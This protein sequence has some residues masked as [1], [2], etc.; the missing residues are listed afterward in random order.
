MRNGYT[1]GELQRL[2]QDR[3]YWR[4]LIGGLCPSGATGNGDN[5]DD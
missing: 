1:W 3:D 4:V 5:D 2:A